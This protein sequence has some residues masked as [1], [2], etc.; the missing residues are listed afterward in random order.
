MVWGIKFIWEMG[1]DLSELRLGKISLVRRD[2]VC[3]GRRDE[4]M[5]R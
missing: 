4:D 5:V 2:I 3:K 1:E